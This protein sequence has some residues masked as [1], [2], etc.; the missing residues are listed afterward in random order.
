ML[1]MVYSL[2]NSRGGYCVSNSLHLLL[3][4]L[5]WKIDGEYVHYEVDFNTVL[6]GIVDYKSTIHV[7]D[8]SNNS[9][10]VQIWYYRNIEI[11]DDNHLQVLVKEKERPFVDFKDYY[12]RLDNAIGKMCE[13]AMDK[14]RIT[15]YGL[16]TTIS[17]GYDAPCCATIAKRHG[18]DTAVTFEA[19][20]KY[21]EDSGVEVAKK[22][23][24]GIIIER[25]AMGHLD[26]EDLFEAEYLASGEMGSDISFGNFDKDFYHKVVFTGDRGD[27]VWAREL[28]IVNDN[29]QFV[30]MLSHLGISER[31]L[32][33][34]YISVPMPLF[35]AS[36]WT[37]IQKISQSDEMAPWSLFNGYDR[38]IPRRICEE[39]GVDRETFGIKKH[40]AGFT[41]RYQPLK[42]MKQ[43]IS[44]SAYD[45]FLKWIKSNGKHHLIQ[46]VCYY[47][48]M[49]GIYLNDFGVKTKMVPKS[50]VAF[51]ANPTEVR[52]LFPWSSEIV[53][54]KYKK[55][56]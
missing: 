31:R 34:D 49:R 15:P 38:P 7:L 14:S 37:S 46:T 12:V 50:E 8:D 41:L 17:K 1:H 19:T 3:A 24:Y 4:K 54:E 2:Q 11:F 29:F 9:M 52:Y 26:R 22:L 53:I 5:N 16:V 28:G 30:D 44:S 43:K 45:N 23:G 20:G 6:N 32:W 21:V 25:D 40:G 47:W 35:G 51:I 39:A 33:L 42:R 48:R 56:L 18:C 36:A 13:N 10:D 27:S 55:A